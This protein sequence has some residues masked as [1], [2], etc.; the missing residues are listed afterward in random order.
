MTGSMNPDLLDN[1]KALSREHGHGWGLA[2]WGD[3]D[4][5]QREALAAC[6]QDSTFDEVAGKAAGKRTSLLV[7]H[8][9]KRSVGKVG[10]RNTHPFKK[11]GWV[12]GH[13][14]TIHGLGGGPVTDS[15]ALFDIILAGMDKGLSPEEALRQA[16]Q[17]RECTA[18]NLLMTDGKTLYA[19]E[20]HHKDHADFRLFYRSDPGG[21]VV[22]SV[23]VLGEPDAGLQVVGNGHLLVAGPTGMPTVLPLFQVA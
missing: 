23:G 2:W 6:H 18:I 13:N 22:G 5:Y 20:Y 8:I 12:L 19:L 3:E 17:G 16:V 4:G 21:L 14:G 9:R 15:E 1:M 11:D 7:A 10:V